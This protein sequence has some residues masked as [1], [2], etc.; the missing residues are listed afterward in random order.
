MDVLN[1]ESIHNTALLRRAVLIDYLAE[2]HQLSFSCLVLQVNV[3]RLHLVHNVLQINAGQCETTS[4]SLQ[5]QIS[6]QQNGR[7]R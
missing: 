3:P 4:L 7:R 5:N 2:M 1:A 6:N